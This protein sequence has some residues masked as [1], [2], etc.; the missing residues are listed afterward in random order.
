[1]ADVTGRSYEA[2]VETLLRRLGYRDEWTDGAGHQYL[3]EKHPESTCRHSTAVCKHAVECTELSARAHL[4]YGPWYDPDFF[5]MDGTSPFGCIHV[6]HWSSPS[7]STRKFWRSIEDHLQYKTFFGPSFLSVNLV[8]EGLDR[9]ANPRLIYDSDELIALHGWKPAVSS[10][11][12]VSFDGALVFP[13]AYAPIEALTRGL[14]KSLPKNSRARRELYNR[15]WEQLLQ[16]SARSLEAVDEIVAMLRVLLTKRRL[17]LSR[18]SR[19]AVQEMQSTCF[20]GRTLSTTLRS[21]NSRYRKGIQHVFIVHEALARSVGANNSKNVLAKLIEQGGRLPWKKLNELS[22]DRVDASLG[23]TW[24][25]LAE[26]PV[27]IAK[28]AG[29]FL[30]D[31]KGGLEQA[32]W[33]PDLAAYFNAL[34]ALPSKDRADFIDSV[35][36]LYDE[37]RS[38]YGVKDV[39]DDLL[40]PNRV[41]RKLDYVATQY[42][43]GGN[44][45]SFVKRLSKDL[46]SPEYSPPH[47][48]VESGATSWV[49]D[50]LMSFFRLGRKTHLVAVLPEKFS[51]ATGESLRIY[52]FNRNVDQLVNHLLQG[53]PI[54]KH[55]GRSAALNEVDFYRCIKPLLAECIWEAIEGKTP[56][57]RAEALLIYRHRRALRVISQS[58]LDP[59]KRLLRWSIPR[60]GPGPTLTGGFN[61]LCK[62]KGWANGA[63]TT[64]ANGL[65]PVTGAI[66][67]TQ[68]VFGRKHIADKTRELAGRLRSLRLSCNEDAVLGPCGVK[69]K[70]FLVVDGDWPVES[71]INLLEA[72]Y[73][74]VY[75][76]GELD[77]LKAALTAVGSQ[78]GTAK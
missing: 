32:R 18:L 41:E 12:C 17:T 31:P 22:G 50:I 76:I 78:G 63:L 72:G 39:I 43:G 15:T 3:Y 14:P 51:A 59:I 47:Q 54:G 46:R 36:A 4:S 28:G 25:L 8:F 66:I 7:D 57:G 55:F 24:Q 33:N 29:V 62:L 10:A 68:S 58:D 40:D 37:Y 45:N 71:K 35:C 44:R 67:H 69:Q 21:T 2:F 73:S 60:L 20:R 6:T 9:L 30:L 26:L 52:A 56:V 70:H 53:A 19:T 77:G 13:R 74:G 34:R 42:L 48:L 61:A 23:S 38:A 11:L 1:V 65:D 5:L 64:K 49:V 27:Q 16:S 75:E